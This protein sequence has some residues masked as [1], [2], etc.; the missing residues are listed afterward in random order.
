MKGIQ[1]KHKNHV[2]HTMSR[3][4][5]LK[6]P[7]VRFAVE[8]LGGRVTAIYSS[9]PGVDID[10]GS[11]D[12]TLGIESKRRIAS[13]GNCSDQIDSECGR[14]NRHAQENAK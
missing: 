5:A 1:R 7:V 12:D 10:A 13:A 3:K 9:R 6:D 2:N 14:K 11:R 8:H 4:L